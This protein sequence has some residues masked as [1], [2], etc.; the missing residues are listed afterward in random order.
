MLKSFILKRAQYQD[1]LE[2][3]HQLS[4]SSYYR[5]IKELHHIALEQS[6]MLDEIGAVIQLLQRGSELQAFSHS[7]PVISAA[8]LSRP[9]T[10]L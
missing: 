2:L 4:L 3:L 8:E 7:L 5:D 6:D 1:I 9:M 10:G